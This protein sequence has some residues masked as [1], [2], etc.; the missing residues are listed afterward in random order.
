MP[1]MR[2]IVKLL[3]TFSLHNG[4]LSNDAAGALTEEYSECVCVLSGAC[5][6]MHPPFF[7]FSSLDCQVCLMWV[8]N[9]I[10]WITVHYLMSTFAT[11]L[12]FASA[13]ILMQ[14]DHLMSVCLYK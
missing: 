11:S 8:I 5:L 7:N 10:A 14:S 3:M 2:E 9:L 1:V 6:S 13:H 12:T 4:I